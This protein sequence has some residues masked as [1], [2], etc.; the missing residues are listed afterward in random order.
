MT[1]RKRIYLWLHPK[2]E[3][4]DVTVCRNCGKPVEYGKL[5]NHTGH[6]ACPEC[7]EEL[8]KRIMEVRE[9]DYEQYRRQDHF[10]GLS[11]EEYK[12]RCNQLLDERTE[13]ALK[14]KMKYDAHS[15]SN[16]MMKFLDKQREKLEDTE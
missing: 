7:F 1:K 4:K 6:D 16:K 5:K 14:P 8:Q 12:K 2:D 9:N 13:L 10:Y 15:F 3:M 11:K